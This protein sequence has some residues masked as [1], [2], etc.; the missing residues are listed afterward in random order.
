MERSS[1]GGQEERLAWRIGHAQLGFPGWMTGCSSRYLPVISRPSEVG[2]RRSA[3][4]RWWR[5]CRCLPFLY[6]SFPC[7]AR[8]AASRAGCFLGSCNRVVVGA[9]PSSYL[10]CLAA[11]SRTALAR[12]ERGSMSCANC[13]YSNN[14]NTCFIGA[15]VLWYHYCEY[16]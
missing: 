3:S 1:T 11:Q 13:P 9:A 15:Q 7:L 10:P 6:T 2:T 12:S 4:L 8:Q 5:G 16:L 14:D